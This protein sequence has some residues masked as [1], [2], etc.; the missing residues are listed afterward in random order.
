MFYTTTSTTTTT[1]FDNIL[2][3]WTISNRPVKWQNSLPWWCSIQFNS[4]QF[5]SIQF[6]STQFNSI[7]FYPIQFNSIQFNSI[8]FTS[9]Q[10]NSI[11]FYLIQF[12]SIQ[13]NSIQYRHL[14]APTF[15]LSRW[16][17][18]RTKITRWVWARWEY[19]EKKWVF[20][21][22]LKLFNERSGSCRC[23]GSAF[24]AADKAK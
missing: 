4:I 7:P 23:T 2:P 15:K 21:L 20:N 9:T 8:Q 14:H 16:C 17:A 13:F 3:S 18:R 1:K 11:Q 10:L 12:N 19:Q 6:T 5:N 22:V 24:Q